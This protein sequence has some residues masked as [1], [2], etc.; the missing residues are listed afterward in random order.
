MH[1]FEVRFAV[2]LLCEVVFKNESSSSGCFSVLGT[3]CSACAER[4][5]HCV[6]D[7]SFGSDVR[8]ARE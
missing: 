3:M 5:A 8:F 4:D 1:N 7:V 2:V 6:R